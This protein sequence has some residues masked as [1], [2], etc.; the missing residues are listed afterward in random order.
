[1]ELVRILI[2]SSMTICVLPNRSPVLF[3][4]IA[5]PALKTMSVVGVRPIKLA[6]VRRMAVKH[7]VQFLRIGP[8]PVR[9]DVVSFKPVKCVRNSQSVVFVVTIVSKAVPKDLPP[10]TNVIPRIGSME[11]AHSIAQN[12]TTTARIAQQQ[13][14]CVAGVPITIIR[15]AIIAKETVLPGPSMDAPSRENNVPSLILAK[16]VEDTRNALGAS[17]SRNQKALRGLVFLPK[18]DSTLQC[19]RMAGVI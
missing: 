2:G 15:L 14:G 1:M 10:I 3:S 17:G 19:P 7:A 18:K 13:E 9:E 8:P 4:T 6:S 11:I 5:N 12:C 16:S